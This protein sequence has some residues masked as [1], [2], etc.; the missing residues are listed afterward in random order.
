M[1]RVRCCALLRSK[2]DV[3]LRD[4]VLKTVVGAGPRACPFS[5][6]PASGCAN[7][8]RHGDLPLRDWLISPPFYVYR[9]RVERE[10]KRAIGAA[11]YGDRVAVH[12]EYPAH[13]G[14]LAR[15][16]CEI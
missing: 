7:K 3:G 15:G 2:A 1:D 9:L 4:C 5:L 16:Y 14:C 13:F 11:A 6:P 10:N 8:G 12:I